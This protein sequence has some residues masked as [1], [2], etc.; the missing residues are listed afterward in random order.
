[1]RTLIIIGILLIMVGVASG[2]SFY[3]LSEEEIENRISELAT[4]DPEGYKLYLANK[5]KVDIQQK[6]EDRRMILGWMGIGILLIIVLI[7]VP[8]FLWAGS[9]SSSRP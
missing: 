7:Y 2:S 5:D 8:Y 9:G 4:E 6:T 1:M 3:G